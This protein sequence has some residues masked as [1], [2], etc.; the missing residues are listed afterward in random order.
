MMT[1]GV[2]V[3][4][5]VKGVLVKGGDASLSETSFQER[6]LLFLRDTAREEA[7]CFCGNDVFNAPLI[8]SFI[9]EDCLGR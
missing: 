1:L 8:R 5:A 4:L 6:Y 2:A 7:A 9:K 3:I